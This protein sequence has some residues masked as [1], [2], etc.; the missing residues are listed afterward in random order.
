MKEQFF[1]LFTLYDTFIAKIP[2]N[3]T[4]LTGNKTQLSL[5]TDF[6]RHL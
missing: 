2:P 6:D 1:L 5:T 3:V 4:L